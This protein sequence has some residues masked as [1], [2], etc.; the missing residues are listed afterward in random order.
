MSAAGR[1]VDGRY[2]LGARLGEGGSGAVF[3]ATQVFT[4]A[5]VA[6]K[7]LRPELRLD[8]ASVRRFQRQ[9]ALTNAVRHPNIVEAIDGGADGD[10]GVPF[11]VY[12]RL[13]GLDL[14]RVLAHTSLTPEAAVGILVPVL[15]ALAH[16]HAADIVHRD[17]KASN[18]LLT[19][20]PDPRPVLIDFGIATAVEAALGEER[21]SQITSTGAIL[22][23][24]HAMSPEQISG[25]QVGPPTD[26][27]SAGV[28][29]YELLTGE[30][31]FL[32]KTPTLTMLK[33]VS[34]PPRDL[35][36]SLPAAAPAL[37]AA[38]ASALA[39]PAADRPTA[40]ELRDALL[41]VF[42]DVCVPDVCVPDV[43]GVER[44]RSIRADTA[45]H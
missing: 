35:C 19:Y 42:P 24:P 2:R 37:V 44:P 10:T 32:A 12:E 5:R 30:R 17:V 11:V 18:V 9:A 33:V 4:G 25:T 14:G 1:V 23:S 29:L 34:Q 38:V 26:V 15:D 21:F 20:A 27:W 13:V 28:L 22:G 39:K 3:E 7:I 16:A 31:P 6:V 40:A 43:G 36:Q 41:A 8:A 45:S